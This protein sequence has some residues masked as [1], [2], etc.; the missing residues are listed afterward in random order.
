MVLVNDRHISDFIVLGDSIS[1]FGDTSFAVHYRFASDPAR[2]RIHLIVRTEE[3][4]VI[5]MSRQGLLARPLWGQ[6]I[7][8]PGRDSDR[9]ILL[10]MMATGVAYWRWSPGSEW[11]EGEWDRFHRQ[12]TFMWLPD[13]T[14]WEGMYDPMAGQMLFNETVPE[15]G[16]TI[17]RRFFRRP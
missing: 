10:R 14:T 3:G 6:W 8:S 15:S 13:S 12:I 11:T 16:I 1:V 17:L 7:G 4:K 9:Q 2:S 5:T